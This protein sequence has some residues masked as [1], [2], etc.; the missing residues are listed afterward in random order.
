M[1]IWEEITGRLAIF[2]DAWEF[3]WTRKKWWLAPIVLILVLASILIIITEA[4]TF[5]PVIYAL[6]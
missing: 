2:K 3:M 1:K 5:G 6:F 4:S